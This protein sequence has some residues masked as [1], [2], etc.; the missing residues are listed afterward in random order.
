MRSS[1]LFSCAVQAALAAVLL[2]LSTNASAQS[3]QTLLVPAEATLH[4]S[5]P[6]QPAVMFRGDV[7]L[8]KA[9]GGTGAMLY[10]APGAVGF[11]AALITHGLL[12]EASRNHEKSALQQAADKVLEPYAP[13]IT[14]ISYQQLLTRA[15]AKNPALKLVALADSTSVSADQFVATVVPAYVMPQDQK[16]LRLEL[17]ASITKGNSADAPRYQQVITAVS[18]PVNHAKPLEYWTHNDAEQLKGQA[19]TLLT[20]ALRVLRLEASGAISAKDN[21]QRTVRYLP[22]SVE[23]MERGQVLANECGQVLLRNLRDEL[24]LVPASQPTAPDTACATNVQ[25]TTATAE[26]PKANATSTQASAVM[27]TDSA[28][29]ATT[30][31]WR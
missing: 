15:Q 11:L 8:D 3:A 22:G 23:K 31:P 20:D 9:G 26:A 7:S 5:L 10:P 21:P 25:S 27:P 28:P 24:M 2:V 13:Y 16:A 6:Q 30:Q 14:G 1:H 19:A 29:A 4:L 18:Q 12:N 17:A